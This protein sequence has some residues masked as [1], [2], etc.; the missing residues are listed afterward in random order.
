[1]ILDT[2]FR[3]VISW[4]VSNRMRGGLAI[5]LLNITFR[6][7]P[8]GSIQYMSG[9]RYC[10]HDYQIILPRHGLKALMRGKGNCQNNAT[11][12]TF[13]KTITAELMW[14]HSWGTR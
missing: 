6:S 14:W 4:A 5:R 2:H 8:K 12:E 13:F 9:S 10:S 1:M 11:I 7:R 3:R